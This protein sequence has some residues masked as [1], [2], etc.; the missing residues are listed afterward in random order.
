MGA[1]GRDAARA[2]VAD[3]EVLLEHFEAEVYERHSVEDDLS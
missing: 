2:K 1:D 3:C